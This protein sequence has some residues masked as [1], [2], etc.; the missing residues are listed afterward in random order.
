M[1]IIRT[2]RVDVATSLRSVSQGRMFDRIL[3]DAPCSGLGVLRRH[4]EAKWFKHETMF[5]RHHLLQTQILDAAGSVLRPGGVLVYSTCSTEREET[6]D[7][8]E[9]VCRISSGWVRESVEP[10]LPSPALSLMTAQGA[11]STTGN[12]FGMDGFYAVRLRKVS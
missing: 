11:L 7:V 6:E 5:A 8:I 3:V 9:S 1:A 12:R 2:M 4:P 10:W